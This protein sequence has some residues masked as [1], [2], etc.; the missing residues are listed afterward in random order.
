M[1][2]GDESDNADLTDGDS[3]GNDWSDV[4]GQFPCMGP[5]FSLN[6]T[7]DSSNKQATA[8]LLSFYSPLSR[9]YV[10]SWFDHPYAWEGSPF[11][12]TKVSCITPKLFLH[13]M[14]NFYRKALHSFAAISTMT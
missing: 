9:H 7:V 14:S 13:T 5:A 12:L 2:S 11:K 10:S 1:S 6:A 3:T 8:Y 4:D